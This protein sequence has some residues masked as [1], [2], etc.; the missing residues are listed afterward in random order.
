MQFIDKR[1]E[2][3]EIHGNKIVSD[4]IEGQ[5]QDDSNRYVNLN[6]ESFDCLDMVTLTKTEQSSLCC[7]CMRTLTERNTTL[8]HII[9]NKTK[10]QEVFDKYMDVDILRDNV[11]SWTKD[12]FQ[13]KQNTPPFPHFIAYQ[14]L[15]ASCNGELPTENLSKI[16]LHQCCNNRRSDNYIYPLFY[17]KNINEEISYSKDGDILY[18]D[19][20]KK[21]I[22]VLNLNQ[23]TLKL[24]RKAWFQIG[25]EY[26][27]KDV[28][29]AIANQIK[30]SEILDDIDIE[31]N[32]KMTL[33]TEL[34]WKFLFQYNW[35]FNYYKN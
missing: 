26:T 32:L 11:I 6:Y 34:Y 18:D 17:L 35:F 31:L 25:I 5:W 2:L 10:K 28:E 19:Q 15:V 24:M 30:R 4:F 14:N 7:Y 21:T 33:K 12:H 23:N 29:Y 9:P 1:N 3:N 13:T 8:E 27:V 16:I 20:Y 22:E